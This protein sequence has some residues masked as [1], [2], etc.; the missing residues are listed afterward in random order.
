MEVARQCLAIAGK[1][2]GDYEDI[3]VGEG[4]TPM[5]EVKDTLDANLGRMPIC[6]ADG[7]SIGQGPAIHMYIA[8]THGLAGA[9]PVE[10]AQIMSIKEALTEL[11]KA[12]RDLVPYG[13]KPEEEKLAKFFEDETASDYAGMA[14]GANRDSRLLKW[15]MN[16][17]EGIVGDGGVAVGSSISL[18]DVLIY[19][20]FAE[21]LTEAEAPD[22]EP[23]QRAPFNDAARMEAAL[24]TCPKLKANCDAVAAHEN[25]KK[26]LG[27]R[28]V[29]GF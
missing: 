9:N 14:V 11:G 3:R 20:S 26:W 1:F 10:T 29:Q 18:A 22:K 13:S 16:R 7:V 2:P 12:F 6:E 19:N 25:I 28:G 15:Y 8:M 4:A 24:A 27:M 23:Y 21:C 5:D 17:L